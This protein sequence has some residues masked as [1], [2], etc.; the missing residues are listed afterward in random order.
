MVMTNNVV[1]WFDRHGLD[2]ATINGQTGEIFVMVIQHGEDKYEVFWPAMWGE[3]SFTLN[4]TAMHHFS[5]VFVNP[6]D[7][8]EHQDLH[9]G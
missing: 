2:W 7:E 6:Y 8:N 1:A 4:R 9:E 5:Q 3:K